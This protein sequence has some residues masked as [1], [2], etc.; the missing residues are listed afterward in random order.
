[1]VIVCLP[2][3]GG[4]FRGLYFSTIVFDMND[5]N[6]VLCHDRAL[7]PLVPVEAAVTPQGMKDLFPVR[8]ATFH[9]VRCCR[10]GPKVVFFHAPC[11]HGGVRLAV[12]STAELRLGIGSHD[13]GFV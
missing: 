1:L 12:D 11:C 9:L 5:P 10:C 2:P 6:R 13:G 8:L 7:P 3:F 4:V